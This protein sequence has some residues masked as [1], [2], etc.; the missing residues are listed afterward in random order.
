M[1]IYQTGMNQDEF[2]FWYVGFQISKDPGENLV[3]AGSI[4]MVLG[5][6]CAFFIRYRV[7][8]VTANGVTPLLGFNDPVGQKILEELEQDAD[9]R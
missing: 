4:L 1:A 6:L 7:I 5:L 9:E 8:A 2:G 3:W